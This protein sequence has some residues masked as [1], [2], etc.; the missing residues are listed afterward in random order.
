VANSVATQLTELATEYPYKAS[1]ADFPLVLVLLEGQKA[2]RLQFLRRLH[3]IVTRDPTAEAEVARLIEAV[4]G[5][6]TR[7]DRPWRYTAQ[8]DRRTSIKGPL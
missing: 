1:S 4:A 5:A 6:G 7:P 8:R 2:P 3:W